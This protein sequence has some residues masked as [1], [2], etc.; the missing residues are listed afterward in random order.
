MSNWLTSH[1]Q[2]AAFVATLRLILGRRGSF[3]GPDVVALPQCPP[4]FR[5]TLGQY[6]VLARPMKPGELQK[7][8][9][10]SAV[11]FVVARI[12]GDAELVD[13]LSEITLG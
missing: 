2:P 3:L 6:H 9:S 11:G 1:V 5:I 13:A 12:V 4:W 10:A 7:H 8:G